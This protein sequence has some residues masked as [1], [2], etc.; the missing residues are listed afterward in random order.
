MEPS[1]RLFL[2]SLFIIS[3]SAVNLYPFS[4]AQAT[5]SQCAWCYSEDINIEV[6]NFKFFGSEAQEKFIV[7]SGG[8]LKFHK[9]NDFNFLNVFYSSVLNNGGFY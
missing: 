3:A 2:L 9:G 8:F 5:L 1:L 7:M 4:P 6:G